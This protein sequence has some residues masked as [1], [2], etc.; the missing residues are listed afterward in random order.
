MVFLA[1][2][3]KKGNSTFQ[4]N[5]FL[6]FFFYPHDKKEFHKNP[7]WI[8]NVELAVSSVSKMANVE[9]P[10]L[11]THEDRNDRT[12]QLF[13]KHHFALIY[14]LVRTRW[15]L[16]LRY[17]S[18]VWDRLSF[19]YLAFVLLVAS[20]C[21]RLILVL[22]DVVMLIKF[23]P[24]IIRISLEKYIYIYSRFHVIYMYFRFDIF[25]SFFF[26]FFF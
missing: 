2:H 4:N 9:H 1:Q 6:F 25:L 11:Y 8:L 26:L 19:W 10:R 5:E 13:M 17:R 3:Q 12:F 22:R 18:R 24:S 7:L 21:T 15:S 16:Y 23:K 20:R 14:A